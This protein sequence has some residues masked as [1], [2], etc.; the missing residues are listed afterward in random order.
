MPRSGS[1]HRLDV[2]YLNN[3][4][5]L[6]SPSAPQVNIFDS[7]GTARVSNAEV[8]MSATG[9]GSYSFSIPPDGPEGTWIAYFTGMSAW[10]GE[11]RGT[12]SFV[13]VAAPDVTSRINNLEVAS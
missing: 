5:E 8:T 9:I 11:L 10:D 3:D 1:V 4:L 13:V 2:Q 6:E 7:E 12:D